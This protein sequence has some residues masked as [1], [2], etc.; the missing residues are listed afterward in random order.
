MGVSGA[1]GNL[2]HRGYTGIILRLYRDYTGILQGIYWDYIGI[3]FP[4]FPQ[5]ATV[6]RKTAFVVLWVV[7]LGTS[8]TP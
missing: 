2:F 7:L 1:Q 6:S 5:D 4:I 8:S 3:I